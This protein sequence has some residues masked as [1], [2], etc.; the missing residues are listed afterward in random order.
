M[1]IQICKNNTGMLVYSKWNS[2]TREQVHAPNKWIERPCKRHL[3]T[4]ALANQFVNCICLILCMNHW[5]PIIVHKI[6]LCSSNMHVKIRQKEQLKR[7][8]ILFYSLHARNVLCHWYSLLAYGIW[9]RPMTSMQKYSISKLHR[10][11]IIP[12]SCICAKSKLI[13]MSKQLTFWEKK[14][15]KLIR[16]IY[17]VLSK[18][19]SNRTKIILRIAQRLTFSSGTFTFALKRPWIIKEIIVRRTRIIGLRFHKLLLKWAQDLEKQP[20]HIVM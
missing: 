9:K 14:W 3:K 7:N 11:E 16:K 6:P 19:Q 5:R 8:M 18:I 17:Q 4:L 13:N 10:L 2:I 1:I 20:L 12:L 15:K